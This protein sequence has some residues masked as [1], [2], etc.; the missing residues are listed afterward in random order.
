MTFRMDPLCIS[1]TG[2]LLHLPLDS[3]RRAVIKRLQRGNPARGAY[4]VCCWAS[5]ASFHVSAAL[6]SMSEAGTL[7]L[8]RKAIAVD[9]VAAFEELATQIQMRDGVHRVTALQRAVD[10]N[11]DRFSEYCR[12]FGTLL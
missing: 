7:T 1:R 12:A 3:V 6:L 2:A 8:V 11:P 5:T 10:E 4:T 9:P